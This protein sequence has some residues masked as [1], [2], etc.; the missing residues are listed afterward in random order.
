MITNLLPAE[1]THTTLDLFEKQPLLITFDNAFTQKVGPSYSP[2]GPMLEFE[3]LGDRN[4]FIEIQKLLLE[5]KCKI[6]RNNDGD[7]RTRTDATNTDAPNFSNNALHSLFSEC[8]VSADAVKISNTN[9][10]Y[11]HKAFI[12]TEFSSGKTAKNTWLV[13]QGYYYEDEPAKIDGTDGRADDVAARKALVANSQENYFIGKPASDILT[14]DKHLL[15]GVTR[16]ISFRRSTND[17]AVISE[18]KKHYKVR[19][20]EANLYVRKMTIADHVLT[21]IEKTLLKTPAVYRYTE[22]LPRT[23]LATTGIR[24]WSHED[25]FSREP[26]R[27]MVIATWQQIKH[28]LELIALILFT[29]RNSI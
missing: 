20:I 13:C 2:E 11:A 16:R 8:T 18:P 22:V 27:R 19:I 4:N 17:F 7:L 29:T 5:I 26:V 23:F 3:V 24:S 12:Q 28:T 15:S 25:I 1:A 10:N 21:A 6:S 9:G 14:C